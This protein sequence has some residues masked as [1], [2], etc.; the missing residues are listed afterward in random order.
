MSKIKEGF[1][2]F[3]E[4]CGKQ[5]A[6]GSTFC[7]YCGSR[8]NG[9]SGNDTKGNYQES[10]VNVTA[11]EISSGNNSSVNSNT[12]VAENPDDKPSVL[13]G[14]IC[15]LIPLVGITMTIVSFT[16]GKPKCGKQYLF[17]TV[18]LPVLWLLYLLVT[19]AFN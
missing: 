6:D 7:K 8:I 18:I 15:I 10:N 3:C 9:D 11:G 5:I 2:M 17:D 13:V 4:K 14:I 1:F 12:K 16:S 19:M